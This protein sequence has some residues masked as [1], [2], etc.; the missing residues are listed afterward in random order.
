MFKKTFKF[1]TSVLVLG[2]CLFAIL[3]AAHAATRYVVSCYG[4]EVIDNKTGLIWKRCF[5]GLSWNPNTKT[6]GVSTAQGTLGYTL[7]GALQLVDIPHQTD[8]SKDTDWRLPNIKELS[9][10]VD[11]TATKSPAI[12]TT[13][14]PGTLPQM[15]WSSTPYIADHQNALVVNFEFGTVETL[16]ITTPEA[17]VR[18]VRAG[19][20]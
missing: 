11:R 20:Q 17:L 2:L 3:P 6:C 18:L 9:S 16:D 4:Q 5:E 13:I 12:N 1:L 10:I 14:F 8:C 19:R 7:K 15:F